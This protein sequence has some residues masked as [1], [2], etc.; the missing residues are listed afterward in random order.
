MFQTYIISRGLR[1]SHTSITDLVIND[2]VENII[3]MNELD[4]DDSE[5]ED[6]DFPSSN[7]IEYVFVTTTGHNTGP[8]KRLHDVHKVPCFSPDLTNQKLLEIILN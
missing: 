5:I 3:I 6:I 4:V 1:E 7:T 8:T 2:I